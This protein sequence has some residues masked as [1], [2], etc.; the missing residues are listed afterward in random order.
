MTTEKTLTIFRKFKD[1]GDIIA[2]F[3]HEIADNSG[4]CMSYQRIG[5]HGAADYSHCIDASI[6]AQPSEY[7][8]LKRELESIGYDLKVRK[9]LVRS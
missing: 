4:N 5:Q 1:S 3:P 7:K 9:K 6:P 8:A 2:L